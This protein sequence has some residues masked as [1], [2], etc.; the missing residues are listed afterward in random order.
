MQTFHSIWILNIQLRHLYVL[1]LLNKKYIREE[2]S[3]GILHNVNS[4]AVNEDTM[5]FH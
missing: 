1:N 3:F 4:T 2:V 5:Y